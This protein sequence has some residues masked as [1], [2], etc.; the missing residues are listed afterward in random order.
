[1]PSSGLVGLGVGLGWGSNGLWVSNSLI[2]GFPHEALSIEPHYKPVGAVDPRAIAVCEGRPIIGL[3]PCHE[4]A[5]GLLVAISNSVLVL[6]L[7][8]LAYS[9]MADEVS[10]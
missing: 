5:R 1:M 8:A 4:A 10:E 7:Q 2:V 9:P 6:V 3:A